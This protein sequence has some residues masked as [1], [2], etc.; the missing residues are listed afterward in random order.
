M[1]VTT[2]SFKILSNCNK[3]VERKRKTKM[4]KNI[5]SKDL[6]IQK[7]ISAVELYITVKS[8]RYLFFNNIKT[9]IHDIFQICC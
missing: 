6:A 7:D 2:N 4:L 9:K 3:F 8:I 5:K 1:K